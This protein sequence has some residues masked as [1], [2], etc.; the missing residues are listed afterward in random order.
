VSRYWQIYKTFWVTSLRRELEFRS[1][2][3]AKIFQNLMWIFFFV[4]ILWVVYGNTKSIAGWTRGEAYVLAATVFLMNAFM[5]AFFFSLM[6]IP[7]HVRMG[8]L[9]F[10][11]TKPVDSQFW[12]SSRKFNFDQIGTVT[13]GLIMLAI[14]IRQAHVMPGL[15]QW[16]AYVLLLASALVIF[17]SFNLALMT[18]GIWLVRVD[19]LWVLGES[20][21]Q[22][23]RFPL[24]IYGAGLQRFLTFVVPLGF[25]ATI[26][27]RQLVKEFNPLM[28]VAGIVWALAAFWLSR[29]FW[30]FAMGHYTSASS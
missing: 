7:S 3:F 8:T 5:S 2:F 16:L 30:L 11:V 19:N 21:M 1:N 18:T 9:D 22:I 6:E 29:K 25:F 4:A 26:P 20:V 17:Y 12:V 28:A 10:V 23:A 15:A 27:A 13:A 14:G 24:D